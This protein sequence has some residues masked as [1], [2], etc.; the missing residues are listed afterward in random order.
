MEYAE[1]FLNE[2]KHNIDSDFEPAAVLP[3]DNLTGK[4]TNLKRNIKIGAGLEQQQDQILCNTA[5]CLRYRAPATYFIDSDAKRYIPSVGDHVV[6]VIEEKNGEHYRV[7]MLSGCNAVLHQLAFEGATKRN[8][9]DLSKGSVVY[10]RVVAS[11]KD[12]ET[13]LVCTSSSGINKE[14]TTGESVSN[15]VDMY[16][17]LNCYA[18]KVFGQLHDGILV[19]LSLTMARKLLSPESVTLNCLAR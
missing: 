10:A 7:N 19:R 6:A 11:F 18:L 9:P 15:V 17:I 14:W 1:Q 5:G 4:V 13:E 8:K 2:A 12:V 3:G 16:I